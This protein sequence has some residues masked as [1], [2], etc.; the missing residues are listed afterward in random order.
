VFSFLSFNYQKNIGFFIKKVISD[1]S[2]HVGGAAAT[3]YFF[4]YSQ[5]REMA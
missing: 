5:I 2:K 1:L 3:I 4:G